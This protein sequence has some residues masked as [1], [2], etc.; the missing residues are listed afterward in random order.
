MLPKPDWIRK[1]QGGK[2]AL[3]WKGWLC[4]QIS[5]DSLVFVEVIARKIKSPPRL[6]HRDWGRKYQVLGFCFWTPRTFSSSNI[7]KAEAGINCESIFS[8]YVG[9]LCVNIECCD[10]VNPLPPPHTHKILLNCGQKET[11]LFKG[12]PLWYIPGVLVR[13]QRL[14]GISLAGMW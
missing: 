1:G 11:A 7:G 4:P 2:G 8:S 10:G 6:D 9:K 14:P 3:K 12:H 5:S 13:K